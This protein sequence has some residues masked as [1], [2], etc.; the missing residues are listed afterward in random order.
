MKSSIDG[1]SVLLSS[2]PS[3]VR[4]ASVTTQIYL[5]NSAGTIT[6]ITHVL[7][8]G[9]FFLFHAMAETLSFPDKFL[10]II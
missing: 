6:E 2:R 5:N 7:N 4:K 10:N 1:T 9:G 8:C 3:S